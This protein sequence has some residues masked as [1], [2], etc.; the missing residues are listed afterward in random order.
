ML[1]VGVVLMGVAAGVLVAAA[2]QQLEDDNMALQNTLPDIVQNMQEFVAADKKVKQQLVGAMES[3]VTSQESLQ[4]FLLGG[5][6]VNLSDSGPPR[7]LPDETATESRLP[8]PNSG[9]NI[10]FFTRNVMEALN[11]GNNTQLD[12]ILKEL[13]S[14]NNNFKTFFQSAMCPEPFIKLGEECFNFQLEDLSWGESRQRCLRIGGDLAIPRNLTEVRLFIGRNFPRKKARNFW[15]GGIENNKNWEW[16][17]GEPVD[18]N[19]WYT[20]EPSGNGDCLAM[21]DGWTRPLSDFPCENARRAI[22][23]RVMRP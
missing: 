8:D 6:E 22:C 21:F 17:S 16:L 4:K 13:N 1:G 9:S 7:H 14:L 23:E 3:L 11:S 15:L 20:N 5:A 19:L 18:P 10:A 2:P 12:A